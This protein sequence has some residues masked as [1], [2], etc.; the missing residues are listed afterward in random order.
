MHD[1]LFLCLGERWERSVSAVIDNPS[2]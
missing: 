2:N 1:D